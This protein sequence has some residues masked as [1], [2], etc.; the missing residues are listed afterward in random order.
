MNR[1]PLGIKKPKSSKY[2]G[3]CAKRNLGG[4]NLNCY[5]C[6]QKDLSASKTLMPPEIRPQGFL[7]GHTGKFGLPERF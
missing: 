2:D 5:K 3:I 6:V 7:C 1:E 4:S